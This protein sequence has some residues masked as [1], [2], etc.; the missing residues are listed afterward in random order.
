M[1]TTS[2]RILF[3]TCCDDLQQG[4]QAIDLG[5]D[6]HNRNY[7]VTNHVYASRKIVDLCR[8][9]I[10]VT[11]P[12]RGG[13]FAE[14]AAD[15]L[16]TFFVAGNPAGPLPILH[17]PLCNFERLPPCLLRPPSSCAIKSN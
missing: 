11:Y 13:L 12:S 6:T 9:N 17:L 14:E 15:I 8:G 10:G 4:K 16:R 7:V 3:P 1:R 5:A 2:I